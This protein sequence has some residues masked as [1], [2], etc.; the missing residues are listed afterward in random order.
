MIKDLFA[1]S[2]VMSWI[3]TGMHQNKTGLLFCGSATF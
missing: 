3:K 1:P 2:S